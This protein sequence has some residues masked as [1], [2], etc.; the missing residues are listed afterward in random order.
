MSK[1]KYPHGHWQKKSNCRKAARACKHRTEFLKKF[2]GAA[3]ASQLA[4]FYEEI[5]KHMKRLGNRHYRLV[6]VYEFESKVF[7]VGLTQNADERDGEHKRPGS[8]VYKYS[9]ETGLQPKRLLMSDYIHVE[10]AAKLEGDIEAQYVARG[11]SKLNKQKTGGVGGNTLKWTYE[12]C[13][14]VALK[15]ET[16]IEMRKRYSAAYSAALKNGLLDRICKH[17]VRLRRIN[18]Y[19]TRERIQ[20]AA[21]R[22]VDK[23]DF[24]SK[25]PA[26]YNKAH[27]LRFIDEVCAHMPIENRKA[28]K[29][30]KKEL[31]KLSKQYVY[32]KDFRKEHPTAYTMALRNDLLKYIPHLIQVSQKGTYTYEKCQKL[33]SECGKRS[34][35]ER[36]FN[37]A[38]FVSKRENWLDDFF[39]KSLVIQLTLDGN[40]VGRY[41]NAREAARQIN[42][43]D[44][45]IYKCLNGKAK[46]AG[47]FRWSYSNEQ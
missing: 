4:G 41:K 14:K 12:A 31:V 18:N 21:L 28:Y 34:E 23:T 13:E 37:G 43:D 17:M 16:R 5:C 3:K 40:E 11:W 39:P 24:R 46:S 27:K 30:T 22:C 6:Y 20:K 25:Y 26:A 47:G 32:L 45:H 8:P 36:K 29:W 19:W 35:F 10:K 44:A 7:Y 2:S 1:T 42:V 33:A 15:C 38:Y 9:T